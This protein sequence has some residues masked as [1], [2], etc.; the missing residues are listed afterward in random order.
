MIRSSSS[1]PLI[2]TIAISVSVLGVGCSKSDD[3]TETA[4]TAGTPAVQSPIV[5]APA[6]GE[7]AFNVTALRALGENAAHWNEEATATLPTAE[8]FHCGQ[9]PA[10][11]DLNLT[12]AIQ[13]TGVP[14]TELRTVQVSSAL[15]ERLQTSIAQ[16]GRTDGDFQVYLSA[17]SDEDHTNLLVGFGGIDTT[18][19]YFNSAT[20]SL[21]AVVAAEVFPANE[22]FDAECATDEAG[23]STVVIQQ[24]LGQDR[25]NISNSLCRT[26]QENTIFAYAE[27]RDQLIA[28]RRANHQPVLEIADLNEFWVVRANGTATVVGFSRVDGFAELEADPVR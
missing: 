25:F 22:L 13:N 12:H 27:E 18:V 23:T 20:D 6:A 8:S 1:F 11:I 28:E 7:S 14:E 19:S 5:A 2:L 16:S 26:L 9:T 4:P 15:C 21:H 3:S 10:T 24:Q 17:W